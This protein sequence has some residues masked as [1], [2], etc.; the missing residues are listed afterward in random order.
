MTV[1]YG[2]GRARQTLHRLTLQSRGTSPDNPPLPDGVFFSGGIR[3]AKP[4]P[5]SRT[6]RSSRLVRNNTLSIGDGA[7]AMCRS[8]AS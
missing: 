5:M 7:I 2:T 6:P 1:I 8:A 3:S 4:S